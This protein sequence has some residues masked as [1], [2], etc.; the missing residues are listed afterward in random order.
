[1]L[2]RI[3]ML[4]ACA[5]LLFLSWSA[6][7]GMQTP[8]QKQTELIILADNEIKRGTYANAES[9]L[10]QA[11][12][13]NTKLT[14]KAL[15]KLKG[16]YL[17][18]GY[19]QDY[20]NVLKKL[21][22]RKDCP[23]DDY[24]EFA[25]YCIT[26]N[27]ITECM[28][29]LRLG[30]ERTNDQKLIDFYEEQ[31][32]TFTVGND[33]YDEV[34][35]YQKGGIQV[36]MDTFWGLA[37]S[38]GKLVIPCSYE[39]ISTFDSVNGGCVVALQSDHKVVSLNMRN[40]KISIF[41]MP[42]NKIGNLSQDKIS[43]QLMSGKWIIANSNLISNNTEYDDIGT[44]ANSAVAVKVADKWG[45]I[46]LNN[47]IIVPYEY[48]EIINNEL[49]QCYFQ[50]AVFAKNGDTIYLIVDGKIHSG[51][52]E[53]AHPFTDDGWAAVK[54]NGKWGFIDKSGELMIDYQF[55]NALSFSQNLAATQIASQAGG[56]E[57][58]G[59]INIYGKSV[60]EPKF[61][62]A[63]SFTNG[64]APVLTELGWQ[65]ITLREYLKGGV[66]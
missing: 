27:K 35:E 6:V 59:Y 17:K 21:T 36:K 41:E 31:R 8:I 12:A 64:N 38:S 32:Y 26:Q 62:K 40:Q 16:V 54:K 13:Y 42:V 55:E 50:N 66:L 1:M 3:V 4:I 51:T 22:S 34:T 39:Q 30:I 65:F 25:N 46:S 48:D 60:I 33:I 23:A 28:I 29:M 52:Y 47:K 56:T 24:V 44:V 63:K 10:L 9:I 61:L 49:G 57:F 2:K 14:T 19:T 18:L 53:D 5:L 20:V 58:W 7:L 11:S 45:V 43:L 37:N 15:G